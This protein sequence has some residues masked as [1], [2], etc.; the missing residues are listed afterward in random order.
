[1]PTINL[2]KYPICPEC[3]ER[4]LSILPPTCELCEEALHPWCKERHR[5]NHE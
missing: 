1:M 3:E 2:D 4:I 5:R